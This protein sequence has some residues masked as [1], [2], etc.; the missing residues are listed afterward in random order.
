[1]IFDTD[2]LIWFLRGDSLA[3][4]LVDSGAN[5][6]ISIVSLMELIQGA[7]SRR[8]G[9]TIRRFLRELN[10]DVIPISEGI[11]YVAAS[12]IEEHSPSDGLQVADALIAATAREAGEVLAT[13]NVRHFRGIAGVTLKAFRHGSAP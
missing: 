1:M 4:R 9:N 6:K 5:R 13:G 12:L 3:A 8:E 10:F 7:K 2:V 11:S